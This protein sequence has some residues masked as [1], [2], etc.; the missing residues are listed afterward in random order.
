MLSL[1]ERLDIAIGSVKPL[2]YMHSHAEHH[3][4]S[5]VKSTNILLNNGLRP[6]FSDFGLSIC[7]R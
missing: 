5:D 7:C 3:V 1:P 4:H 2:S 6:K